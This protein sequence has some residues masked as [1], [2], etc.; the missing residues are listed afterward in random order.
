MHF[1]RGKNLII[2][3]VALFALALPIILIEINLLQYTKGDIAFPLDDAYL[4]A[5]VARNLAFYKVWGLSKWNFQPAS[6]SLLYPLLLSVIFFI[7]GSHLV[8][9]L[10][11][12]TLL[13]ILFLYQLQ[14][15]LLRRKAASATQLIVLLVVTAILPLP[16]LVVS[17]TESVLQLLL[18]FL[19]ME[20]LMKAL[21]ND[22]SSLPRQVYQY[23]LLAVAT[24]YEDLLLILLACFLL[25]STHRRRQAL[26]LAAF[27]TA[28]II[29]FGVIS[30]IKGSY[31]LP[32]PLVTGSHPIYLV[33][34]TISVFAV[35][36]LLIRQ[37]RR[38]IIAAAILA[39]PFILQNVLALSHFDRDSI[40]IYEQ[41]YPIAAFVH[42]YYQRGTIGAN[43]VAALTYFSEGRKLDYT[44]AT[45]IDIA[46][47]RRENSWNSAMADSLTRKNGVVTAILSDS[48]FDEG[49]P[50][51]WYRIA[52]WDIPDAH[53]GATRTF[54][55]Y[56]IYRWDSTLQRRLHDYQPLLPTRIA[57][58]YY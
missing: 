38:P 1:P 30:S 7:L 49:P 19:F 12:N 2:L 50:S 25:A 58:H 14:R 22:K 5:S 6:A 35:S 57:V 27:A 52:S 55:F 26:K 32:T 33:L 11:L 3:V 45:S 18:C 8:I 15:A 37:Y 28:P 31:F 54:T 53:P 13:A 43:D 41:Q 56:S 17:G 16:L 34:L 23:P 29:V 21:E 9:P 48:L 46:Q 47:S 42:R 44:G 40:R 24:R 36:L 20:T 4:N 51:K 39:L 10:I